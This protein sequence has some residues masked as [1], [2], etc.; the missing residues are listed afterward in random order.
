MTCPECRGKKTL[1]AVVC[2]RQHDR[3][4]CR[5]RRLPC[6]VCQGTGAITE[7]HAARIE[8]GEKMRKD[9]ISRRLSL[10]EEAARLGIDQVTLSHRE[11]GREDA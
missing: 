11:Q 1:E 3:S 8:A 9:R 2:G 5:T 6:H 7:E 4:F 10:R